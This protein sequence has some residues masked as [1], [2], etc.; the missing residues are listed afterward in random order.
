VLQYTC[1]AFTLFVR[2][3]SEHFTCKSFASAFAKA[4][5]EYSFN[6]GN[7]R[8]SNGSVNQVLHV[9]FD[10]RQNP[11]NV[12]TC[13]WGVKAGMVPVWVAGKTV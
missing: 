6:L 5:F 13:S 2:D 9:L 1:S 12:C 3:H 8:Y 10:F 7:G 4:F 11:M